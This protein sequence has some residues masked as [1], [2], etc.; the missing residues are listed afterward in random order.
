MLR[1]AE[2]ET[3]RQVAAE[4]GV[5]PGAVNRWRA[6]FVEQRPPRA[7]RRAPPGAAAIDP[8]R[9]GRGRRRGDP[10]IRP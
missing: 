2:G 4:L 8:V 7:G 3:N 6:R 5:S 9:S 1:C 10:G